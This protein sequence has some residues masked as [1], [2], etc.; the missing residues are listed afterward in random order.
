MIYKEKRLRGFKHPSAVWLPISDSMYSKL[1]QLQIFASLTASDVL[2]T[3][4]VMCN[5]CKGKCWISLWHCS[6]TPQNCKVNHIEVF[7]FSPKSPNRLG[8]Q[9]QKSKRKWREFWIQGHSILPVVF[10][11]VQ[12]HGKLSVCDSAAGCWRFLNIYPFQFLECAWGSRRFVL[13]TM[14]WLQQ[15][16]YAV[17]RRLNTF[18]KKKKPSFYT[19]TGNSEGIPKHYKL[20]LQNTNIY[21]K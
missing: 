4:K 10:T 12:K 20:N 18:Y 3:L 21:G 14:P 6:G 9:K 1:Q 13:E 11:C 15:M 19:N 5:K 8:Q 16:Q 2:I 7:F 17:I